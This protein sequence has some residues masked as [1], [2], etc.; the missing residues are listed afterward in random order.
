M[1][2]AAVLVV[3]VVGVLPDVKGEE[4]F[5]ALGDGVIGA[6][7]LG[8]DQGAIFL[9]GEPYPAAAK[10]GD[11]FGLELGLEG[12]HTP[13][14]LQDLGRQRRLRVKPAMR[15]RGT[16]LREVEV[17][18]QDLAGVVEDGAGGGLH[19]LFQRLRLEGRVGDELV[20]VV[21]VALEVLAVVELNGLRAD[22]W[23]Q[24]VDFVREIY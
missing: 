15:V 18:I 8:D 12:I 23:D 10:E 16:E 6:G 3:E 24:R 1:G 22:Y 13:P 20:E 14:L 17:V 4:R 11:A 9:R 7:L 19:D 5:E 21:H 2:G